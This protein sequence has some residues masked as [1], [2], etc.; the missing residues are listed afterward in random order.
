MLVVWAQSGLTPWRSATMASPLTSKQI[1]YLR[2]DAKNIAREQSCPLTQAQDEI[3]KRHGY[4]NWA[5][6]VRSNRLERQAEPLSNAGRSKSKFLA[7][8]ERAD[9]LRWFKSKLETGVSQG[10]IAPALSK[11]ERRLVALLFFG[12]NRRIIPL[13][14]IFGHTALSSVYLYLKV[15]DRAPRPPFVSASDRKP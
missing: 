1:A 7:S 5:L 12:F 2:S 15:S 9:L 10:E 3:A 14:R 11:T 4:K 6:L 13:A 8:G